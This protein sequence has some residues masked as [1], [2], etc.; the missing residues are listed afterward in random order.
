MDPYKSSIRGTR[1]LSNNI[2]S[3]AEK[4][5]PFIQDRLLLVTQIIPVRYAVFG[6]Q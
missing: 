3:L 1:N 6:L 4:R 5:I 2:V